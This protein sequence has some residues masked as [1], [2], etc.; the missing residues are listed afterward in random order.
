MEKNM[1]CLVAI[2]LILCPLV[3]EIGAAPV[4]PVVPAAAQASSHFDVDA[5]T[6]AWLA[7]VPAADKT[8]SDAYFEGGYWLILW[9]FVYTVAVMILL[10]ET[11]WSARMR[12][13]AE[14]I[15]RRRILQSFLYWIEFLVVT[16]VLTFPLTVYE[17]FFREHQYGLSNQ[18]FGSWFRDQLIGLAISLVL[19]G[20]AFVI[21][22]A[23]VRRLPGTWHWWGAAF[24]VAFFAFTVMI[25]P[26][27]LLPLFNKYT[28]LPDGSLKREILSFARANGIPATDVY[29]VNASRQSNRVSANVSGFL[30]TE[31]ITLNDNLLNRCSPEAIL[32]V[33]GHEMGHYV[34]HHIL[35]AILFVLITLMILF[36]ILRWGLDRALRWRGDRWQV[37]D[38]GDVAVLPLAVLIVTTI[39]FLSTPVGNSFTR[40][41]EYEA[42]IFG[43][44][45]ARQPDGE[46]EVDLLLGEYRKLS[47]G[48]MEEAIFFDHPSGRTRI[49]AAMRWKAE[50]LCLFDS[51]LPCV[52]QP[53][54]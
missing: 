44:N 41:Q 54:R 37:R 48:P 36:G 17:G 8:R 23:I 47:P 2:F 10:L 25:A 14:R 18:N 51:K 15:S 3:T 38:T 6:D 9:D 28:R 22:M 16:A 50:N 52:G 32:S 27:F 42:D 12:S 11:R 46:A 13:L 7:T 34:M 39:S 40:M 45:A 4:A 19:G 53:E 49:R 33:M 21:V 35:N 20:I 5:A 26:V 24:G 30:G 31:R 43:L 29:E 1:S